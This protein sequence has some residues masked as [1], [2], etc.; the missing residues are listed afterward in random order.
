[1]P[2]RFRTSAHSGKGACACGTSLLKLNSRFARAQIDFSNRWVTGDYSQN[3]RSVESRCF[4]NSYACDGRLRSSAV[5]L[6]A[7]TQFCGRFAA[8]KSAARPA[9][10]SPRSARESGAF[11][12][13]YPWFEAK[14]FRRRGLVGSFIVSCCYQ[15]ISRFD[16][17]LLSVT[18][19]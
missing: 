16:Q 14:L 11:T 18:E 13:I 9:S 19:I 1:M 15:A 5:P 8:S 6:I 17:W 2:I 4:A 7:D 12:E 3:G 10:P